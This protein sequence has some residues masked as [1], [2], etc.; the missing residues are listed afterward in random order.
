MLRVPD[1]IVA[2]VFEPL[3]DLYERSQRLATFRELER[4][5][6][7][8]PERL[9]KL[10]S[11]RLNRIAIHAATTSPFYRER[12]AAAGIEPLKVR[13]ITDLADLPPLRKSEIRAE[14]LRILSEDFRPEELVP[15]KTGGSTGEAL[16]IFCDRRGIERRSGAALRADTWSG[17]RLGQPVAAVWGNPPHPRTWRN[18]LRNRLKDRRFYLDTMKIDA[19]AIDRFVAEWRRW[20]PGLLYGHAHSLFLLAEELRARGVVLRPRGIVSTSM[21]LLA[22][23]RRAIEETFGVPVTDRYGCEEVSLVACECERHD[24]LHINAEHAYVEVLRDDGSPCAPGEDGRIVVTEFVNFGMPMLRYDVG[25]RGAASART[26]PC[27]RAAPLLEGLTGRSADFLVAGDGSRVA[28]ISLIERTLTRFDGIHQLQL[29]QTSH[30]ELVANLVP[31]RGYGPEIARSVT[32]E[33][34]SHLGADLT[35]SIRELERIPQERN[36]KYRFAICE[37]PTP[38][39]RCAG[40]PTGGAPA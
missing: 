28:G 21:M 11:R 40:H 2:A 15:A 34:R 13:D 39:D 23:E 25:D 22:P 38:S 36:G 19:A 14:G 5:Q 7:W 35:V 26:C 31:G 9:A 10:R 20:R 27:G 6:W 8:P 18:H 1:S 29:V 3:W 33:L 12:F 17:W 32:E 16:Q 4:S 30:R 37:L 24:G